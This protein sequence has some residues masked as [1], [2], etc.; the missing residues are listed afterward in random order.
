VSIETM[1]PF[2]MA[3]L[4][5]V[6]AGAIIAAALRARGTALPPRRIWPQVSI[7]AF[8]LLVLG[9]G[10]VVWAEQF[11]S[12]GLA[13]V[14]VATSPFWMVGVEAAGGGDR[15]TGR[16]LAGLAVGFSGIV[17]LVWPELRAEG[18][19]GS[20]FGAGLVALQIA[21]AGWAVGSTLSRRHSQGTDVVSVTALQM[22]IGGLMLLAIGTAAGEW[23]NLHVSMRSGTAFFYLTT[24]GSIGGFV[25]YAYALKH[26][27]VALVSLYAYINPV[28]AVLLGVLLLGEPFNW[29]M[30]VAATIV[31]AGVAIVRQR[32]RP[33]ADNRATRAA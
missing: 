32:P 19:F 12:S 25:A 10:G 21:S 30:A 33:R 1:P 11:V 26:L 14:I 18:G 29:R 4:R 23:P 13:A 5:W 17:M 22:L 6:I 20:H 28:I 16:A 31:L 2:V 7:M 27:P 3:G 8:L 15:M 24:V 9:N